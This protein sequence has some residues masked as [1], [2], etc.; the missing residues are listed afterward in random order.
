VIAAGALILVRCAVNADYL[1]NYKNGRFSTIPEVLLLYLPFGENYVAP[2]NLGNA[3]YQ[4]GNYEK[5]VDYY[6]QALS[7]DTPEHPAREEECRIRVNLALSL[8]HTIDFDNLDYSNAEAV[9]EAMVT[10]QQARAILTEAECA[11]EPVGSDDGHYRDADKLKHDIDK[12][13]EQLQSQSDSNEDGRNGGGDGQDENQDGGEGQDENQDQNDGGSGQDKKDSQSQKEEEQRVK[14]EQARQDELKRQLDQHKKDLE[15]AN[16][17]S[18]DNGY[19][20][21]EGGSTSGYGEGTLW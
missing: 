12:M 1:R 4:R 14:E 17:G 2:Y 7:A 8:C 21:I 6:F 20:Y 11:S 13:L 3:E 18:G 15:N 10:L 5:A 16:N 19:N 9:A